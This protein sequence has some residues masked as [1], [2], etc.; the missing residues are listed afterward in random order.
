MTVENS[1]LLWELDCLQCELPV[2][3]SDY[4]G[5]RWAIKKPK[6]SKNALELENEL[7][8]SIFFKEPY[9]THVDAKQFFIRYHLLA[10]IS[11]FS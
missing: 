9:L 1:L 11:I 2:S 7:A 4:I 5:R 3:M 8:P 6:G 10:K